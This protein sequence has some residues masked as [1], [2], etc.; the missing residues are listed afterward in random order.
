MLVHVFHDVISEKQI[1]LLK[2]RAELQVSDAAMLCYYAGWFIC[3]ETQ[4]G[5]TLIWVRGLGLPYMKS[6]VGGGRG[7]PKSRRKEGDL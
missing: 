2:S 4:V 5:L 1:K 6:A 3:S 7:S